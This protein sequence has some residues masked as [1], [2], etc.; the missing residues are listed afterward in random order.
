MY[1]PN[2]VVQSKQLRCN[3]ISKYFVYLEPCLIDIEVRSSTH[4][5][6]HPQFISV[7]L[8]TFLERLFYMSKFKKEY[9]NWVEYRKLPDLIEVDF[10]WAGTERTGNYYENMED[11]RKRALSELQEA[12]ENNKEFLLF[13][14]GSSTSWPGMTTSRSQVRGLMRSK[15]AT[16]YISRKDCIQHD[17]V[18]VAAIKPK[19][20][21]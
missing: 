14:H 11:V 18:F 7:I 4:I 15:D 2:R 10:H 17:S 9:K 20:N 21:I 1:A 6:R 8:R 16:P 19:K 5:I 12:H 13:I 3:E